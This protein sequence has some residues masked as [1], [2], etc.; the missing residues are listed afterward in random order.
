MVATLTSPSS[1]RCY[2]GLGGNL[3][4]ELGT[5]K[6][7][8]LNAV[9]GLKA[10]PKVIE[11]NVSSLYAS[12]PMGPQ[13]QPDFINVVVEI[14]TTL[15]AHDLLSFCQYLEQQAQRVRL[16]RWGERSLDVDVLLY[17][18]EQIDTPLLK[19]PHPGITERNFVLIP[20]IEL[21][22]NVKINGVSITELEQSRNWTGLTK[23]S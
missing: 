21:N 5:P 16:R 2:L 19:V 15:E 12:K 18:D 3:A 11:V 17:G 9:Q 13:D 20:L 4:N 23:L 6:Q 22:S 8:I 7:H 14:V 1:V 10:H